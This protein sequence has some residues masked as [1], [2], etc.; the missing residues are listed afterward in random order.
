MSPQVKNVAAVALVGVLAYLLYSQM[1]GVSLLSGSSV[2]EV[3]AAPG[4]GRLAELEEVSSVTP[5]PLLGG[6]PSYDLGGR[7]LFQYGQAKPPPPSAEELERRRREEEARLKAME[8]A[9]RLRREQEE[10]R[11]KAQEEAR[12][13]LEEL[14]RQQQQKTKAKSDAIPVAPTKAPPPPIDL[15]L[16]GY[17][18]PMDSRIA[19]FYSKDKEIVLGRKGEVIEGRF[20]VLDIGTESVEMGYVDPEHAGS[21]KV[22]QLGS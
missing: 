12:K 16:I 1:S 14:H 9:A 17:V 18:G 4:A 5:S 6:T 8:E 21:S 20:R 11:R 19:V 3:P 22:I 15:K 13:A 7:N 10:A 2:P